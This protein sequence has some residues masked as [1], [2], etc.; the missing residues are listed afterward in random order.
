MCVYLS[1]QISVAL[2]LLARVHRHNL[3][4]SLQGEL[5]QMTFLMGDSDAAKDHCNLYSTECGVSKSL[6]STH[7]TQV[8]KN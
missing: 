3:C 4:L 2:H 6:R 8:N 5:R 1:G 7:K